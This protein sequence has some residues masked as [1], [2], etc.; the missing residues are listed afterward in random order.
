MSLTNS[1]LW[2][3]DGI[4]RRTVAAN[5]LHFPVLEAGEGP[6]VLCLHGFPDHARSWTPLLRR[7]AGIARDPGVHVRAVH[8]YTFNQIQSTQAWRRAYLER[9]GV[10][11]EAAA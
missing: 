1:G 5:G 10:S 7:L 4:S 9:L 2:N 8:F 11:I 3:D 6:L